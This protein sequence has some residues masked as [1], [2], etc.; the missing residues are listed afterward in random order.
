MQFLKPIATATLVLL[1]PALAAAQTMLPSRQSSVEPAEWQHIDTSITSPTGTVKAAL[2]WLDREWGGVVSGIADLNTSIG[3]INTSIGDVNNSVDVLSTNLASLA[4]GSIDLL[5]RVVADENNLAVN[6]APRAESRDARHT[7][8]QYVRFRQ[9]HNSTWARTTSAVPVDAWVS[10]TNLSV[11]AGNT[12]WWAP[13]PG[14]P[15]WFVWTSTN[16]VLMRHGASLVLSPQPVPVYAFEWAALRIVATNNAH[17]EFNT[18]AAEYQQLI[19]QR[20]EWRLNR[21]SAF[22]VFRPGTYLSMQYKTSYTNVSIRF[23]PTLTFVLMGSYEN[24]PPFV[25]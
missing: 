16:T 18:E 1:L 11:V 4:A 19:V 22:D 10:V 6:Y 12:N 5:A 15:G 7:L 13:A 25:P 3:D 23:N 14:Q 8:A 9:G 17:P 21:Q 20:N 2:D 24:N